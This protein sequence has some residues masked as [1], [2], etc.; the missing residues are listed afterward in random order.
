MKKNYLQSEINL[1]L[2]L[3]LSKKYILLLATLLLLVSESSS[4]QTAGPNNSGSGT[5]IAGAN[6]DWTTPGNI[7]NTSDA[8]YATAVF[9]MAGNTDNLL[10]KNYGFT[11]PNN[12]IINGIV[13]TVNRRTNAINGGRI[14][15]DNVV[16]LVKG[17]VVTG[18][19]KAVATAYGTTFSVATYGSSTD[20]WG[21]TW[22]PADINDVNFGA[23]ISVN[24][25]NSLT[26]TVDYLRITIHYTTIGLSTTNACEGSNASV[27]ITG[28]YIAGTT[29]VSFNGTSASFVQNSNT[30]VTATLPNGATS[31]TISLT[32]PQGTAT[33]SATFML[34]P[35]PALDVI[36]GNTSVC[37]GASTTL[38]NTTLGGNWS[39]A[40]PSIATINNSGIVS[41]IAG[42]NTII[43][44]TYTDGNSCSNS[45]T[46]SV[47]VNAAPLVTAPNSVCMG[48]SIQLSPNTGGNWISNNT[49]IATIDNSG[50]VTA[51]DYGDV[52]FTFTDNTTTCSNTTNTVVVPQPMAITTQPA[53]S[54][55]ICE[56][57]LVALSVIASGDNLS[58]QWFKGATALIN[59]G[60]ISGVTT[61]NLNFNLITAADS[62]A[63]YHCVISNG[64]DTDL[65]SDNAAIT[66]NEQSVGGTASISLPNVT[67][68][69]R[70]TT[71]CHF[72]S[73]SIYLSGHIGSV[74][75]WESTTNGGLTWI[76]IANTTDTL[77]YNNITQTTFYRAVV[78]NGASCNLAYSYVA[79]VDVI[80]NI[81]PTPVTATPQTICIGGSSVLYSESGFATSSYI[82]EGGTFSNANPDNWLVDGCGNCLNAGGSNTTE[83]PFRLSAT[84][85]GTYSGINYASMGKFAI[86]NGN[87]NS[88]MQTPI[89][90]T[91]GLTTAELSFNH[92]FNLQAGASVSV[93]LSLDGGATY[94]VVLASFTGPSTRNPYNA[95]PNQT[96]DLSN[97]IGQPNLRVRFV[98][99]GTV[100]SS[101]AIDNILI[102]ESPAN[103]TTQWIDSITGEVISTTATATVSPTV[104]TTY[105]VTSYLNGCT[106]YGPEGTTYITVTVNERP[107]ANIGPSQT[108]C[109]GNPATFS[110]ALTGSAPWSITYSNG[111]TTTTVNNINTNPYVFNVNGITTN[112]T[113]T[114]TALSDSKCIANST[115]ITGA[116]VVTVLNGTPGLWTGMISNDWFDCKN[117]AGGMPSATI[118]A[119]IP[120]G[121]VRMP[122]I[123]PSTSSFAA[124]YGNIARAQDVIIANTASLTMTANSDLYVS[125]D[126]K[127][128]GTFLP[129]TGT[130]TFN[131]STANQ[132]QTINAG[133]NTN[134]TFYNLTLNNSNSAKGISLVNGFEL[135]VENNLSLL[136]GDLRLTGEA[137]LVQNGTTANPS[138]GTGRLLK[139]QQGTQSSYHYNYW[140]SPV[141]TNGINYNVSSVLRD[142][143]DSA[144]NPFNPSVLNFGADINFA[145]G[146]LTFPAKLSTGWMYKFTSLSSSYAGWQHI[147]ENGT[148]N[149]A[150][151][152]T[153]KGPT[154]TGS[155]F[156]EQNYV[157]VGKPNNGT[158]GIN[159]GLNQ[160]Y[161][162]G[163]PYPSAL[164]ADEFIKDNIKDGDG[165]AASNIFNGALYFWDHFGGQSHILNQYVG[166]YATYTLMGGV[167]A[168]SNDPLTANNGSSG[169]KTPKRHIAVA[170]GF[171][172][173]TG[174]SSDLGT[175]NP[176][177]STPVTG[178][179]ITFKNSQ[180][181]F[182]T[183]SVANSVFFRN[184]SGSQNV[185]TV[186]DDR[187]KIRLIFESPNQTYRQI[188]VGVDQNAT[189]SFDIGYDAPMIEQNPDDLYW[190]INDGKYTI[191]A[192]SNFNTNQIIP[193]GLKTSI[194]GLSIIKIGG[195]E[196][197]AE[198]TEIYIHD[199]ETGIDYNIRNSDFTMALPIGEYN[200]RFSLRFSGQ[201][202]GTN[203]P[204]ETNPIIYF[205]NNDSSLNISNQNLNLNLKSVS[206]FNLL[207][208]LIATYNLENTNQQNIRIPIL[209]L[210]NG[211]YIVKVATDTT[212]NFSQKILKN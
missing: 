73:G 13:L 52:T 187:Q 109:L 115:D 61:P 184:Q 197:I 77:N 2:E 108:I 87:Y 177:L 60:N 11:I 127:N 78:Q 81:R 183:E 191:Q 55:T 167:V 110:V 135:T 21:T 192:V 153:M 118:N 100:N 129:G 176:N 162:V 168:L 85:G 114:I 26:A 20:T 107:T 67:P 159:I 36:T 12:A 96:I 97:Y 158:I 95:F 208:Q 157:F 14:T 24:A 84:N 139:D 190:N 178:G 71:I 179:T 38:S 201:S 140:S 112:R 211:T 199:G 74:I 165:R 79:L 102:P 189:N 35:L 124:L 128:S 142:G 141:T 194:E 148:V 37:A 136:S 66:V 180:R 53:V 48:S 9:A 111:S 143:S 30:Q 44:Y 161:L 16:S 205:T 175:N 188:L 69:V 94:T 34:N 193:I 146:A 174:S 113:F 117:W 181:A 147:G 119:Q 8:S 207:G 101:W 116:A 126:W 88:I 104:T 145:D 209:N 137:Q 93:E 99:N 28:N 160:S 123:D 27:I 169:T 31:G 200:N 40:S 7:T 105:A 83:G 22:T 58:Y 1:L 51:L 149:P 89:F 45:A 25:N 154:G 152:F 134:E 39:S 41:G 150:E 42:G 186:N 196:N 75:R 163:N 170:Q 91:Y 50:L 121:V 59:G 198:S 106:S 18:N 173:G 23:V 133:I 166:G 206:L 4:A 76:P 68:V 171:F 65:S 212:K 19:N 125:R 151:G 122:V 92:A 156:A 144:T 120:A 90:N 47:T 15:R 103:L 164:D 98:Y 203:N 64:C 29:A 10:G 130:V 54:Q 6:L 33:S 172:I 131:S 57:N 80:P 82:A 195:L 56:N 63:D 86:A 62:A 155:A 43:T 204:I 46:T 32:T 3:F 182:K 5:F 202:L 132:I 70:T 72:G 210:A 138:S 185:D 17:G 49:N